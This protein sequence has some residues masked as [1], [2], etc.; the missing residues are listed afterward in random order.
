MGEIRDQGLD[1]RRKSY[2]LLVAKANDGRVLTAGE[3]SAMSRFEK[4]LAAAGLDLPKYL[5]SIEEVEAYTGYKSRTIYKAIETGELDRLADNRFLVAAVDDFLAAKG[6]RPQVRMADG[7]QDDGADPDEEGGSTKYHAGN[8]EA[9][10]RHFRAKREQIIVKRLEGELIDR[11][12][13][14]REFVVRIHEFRT[15]LLLLKGRVSHK[16]AKVAKIE[17]SL[18]DE[19]LDADAREL[20][21]TLSRKV[22]INV[23]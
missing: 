22:R 23:D 15:A 19:I 7:D 1:A 16:I 18:I 2:E 17:T 21:R 9:K 14:I 4:E 12:E 8:E 10:Y 11:E 6:K 5:D 13:M 3:I 20:L